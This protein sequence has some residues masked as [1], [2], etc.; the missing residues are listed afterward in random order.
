MCEC[1]RGR[2]GVFCCCT[3]L[4][5]MHLTGPISIGLFAFYMT[6]FVRSAHADQFNW[7]ILFWTFVIGLPRIIFYFLL[8][9]DTLFRRKIYASV[10][11]LTAF[12]EGIIYIVNTFIIFGNDDKYCERVYA[13]YWMMD[14]WGIDC[15]WSI[16]LFEFLTTGSLVFFCY[17]SM[18]AFDHYHLGFLN[19]RLKQEELHRLQMDL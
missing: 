11:A 9:A 1:F 2:H 16:F 14:D 3:T 19:P 17:A 5:G 18:G 6:L 13:I 4:V 7:V 12:V 10:L 8:F 15:G